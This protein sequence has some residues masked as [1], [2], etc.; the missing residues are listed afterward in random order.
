MT[1]RKLTTLADDARAIALEEMTAG[2]LWCWA[3]SGDALAAPPHILLSVI[4]HVTDRLF[5][6]ASHTNKS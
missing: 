2:E 1:A 6:P 4:K 5:R 3:D